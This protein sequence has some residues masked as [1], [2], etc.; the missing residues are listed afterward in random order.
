[1][2]N[3]ILA[4]AVGFLA[5]VVVLLLFAWF[6]SKKSRDVHIHSSVTEM[7]AVGELVVF[8]LITKE[9]VTAAEHWLGDVGKNYLSWL[10]STKKMALIFEFGID[11]K[12]DL[13]SSEFEI[14]ELGNDEYRLKMPGCHYDTYIR[15]ISFY[16]EQSSRLLPW[17]VPDLVNKALGMGFDEQDKNRLKE[18]ARAQA[19]QMARRMVQTMQSDVQ[20]SARQT[21][22]ALARGFGARQVVVDFSQSKLVQGRATADATDDAHQPLEAGTAG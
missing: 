2:G 12:Y 3:L 9:I 10:I 20:K 5:A 14:V 16:D 11:F 21:M 17:L 4:A 18:E 7:R 15:D 19:D 13:R 22:E 8:K 1:M 6:R